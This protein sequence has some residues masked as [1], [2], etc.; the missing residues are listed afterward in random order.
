MNAQ[1]FPAVLV[2]VWLASAPLAVRGADPD[3]DLQGT[4]IATSAEIDGKPVERD[5]VN[6]TRFIFQ[7]EKLLIPHETVKGQEVE[8]TYKIVP[9]KSP[10]QIDIVMAF[11][12]S[13]AKK[14]MAGIYEVKGDQLKF[15]YENG[16]KAENRP[17]KFATNKDQEVLIVFKR[18]KP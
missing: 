3:R 13:G 7:G 17:T 15:C 12:S 2:G 4:W 8:F 11:Q 16:G 18:Q 1:S 10:K 14:T 6:K 5:M 9:D